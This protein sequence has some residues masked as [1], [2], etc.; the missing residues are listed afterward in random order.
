VSF[1]RCS[2]AVIVSLLLATGCGSPQ[3]IPASDSPSR[4]AAGVLDGDFPDP[5]VLRTASGYYA[6]ATGAKQLHLQV[7]QSNDLRAWSNIVEA[8]PELPSWALKADGLTWAPSAI[9]RNE[10]YILYYATRHANSGFQCISRA[11]S[12]RPE[13]PYVD[14]S[15]EPLLCQ[16]G[17]GSS[18]CGSIDPSP[19]LDSGGSLYLAWKSDENSVQCRSAPRIWAQALT[20]DGLSVVGSPEILLDMDQ[21]WE[22]GIIEAPSVLLH[23]GRY[24]LFYS[25]NW[26]DSGDYAIGYATCGSPTGPC[27][28]ATLAA[29]YWKGAGSMRGAGGQELFVGEGGAVWMA[30]HAWTAPKT[31]YAA[32]GARSLRLTPMTFGSSGEPAPLDGQ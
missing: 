5:F 27:T 29:P 24:L 8:L 23:G 1:R 11:Q 6:F 13:G 26:Y 25:A 9:V 20:H 19:F 12:R 18:F 14:D 30:Y 2:I 10:G 22:N 15:S 31:T 28:K 7:A 4:A 32:G 16:V 21:S 3:S 17:M